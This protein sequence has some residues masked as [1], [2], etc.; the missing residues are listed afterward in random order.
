M[1]K[2]AGVWESKDV[3]VGSHAESFWVAIEVRSECG[4]SDSDVLALFQ[5][6]VLG[7]V[8]LT[9][10]D[11]TAVVYNSN[12]T[13]VVVNLE[14]L[15]HFHLQVKVVKFTV[16]F[17]RAFGGNVGKLGD[18]ATT[19]NFLTR[20]KLACPAADLGNNC[21][22]NKSIH[23]E[24]F[25]RKGEGNQGVYFYFFWFCIFNH[26]WGEQDPRTIEEHIYRELFVLFVGS[27]SCP[28]DPND[29]ANALADW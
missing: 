5:V 18:E 9:M 23:V 7:V 10:P 19:Q 24:V 27:H 25:S 4:S 1:G 3:G 16:W 29:L 8:N 13:D 15:H 14:F 20:K 26:R 12:L 17:L 11:V 6:S 21:F 2:F 22:F 28:V